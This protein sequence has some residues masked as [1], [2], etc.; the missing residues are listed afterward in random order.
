M[1]VYLARVDRGDDP[2]SALLEIYGTDIASL[3]K[4][5]YAYARQG[6]YMFFT[7]PFDEGADAGESKLQPLEPPEAIYRLSDLLAHRRPLPEQEVLIYAQEV[8]RLVPD[9]SG[10]HEILGYVEDTKGNLSEARKY[11]ELAI[12]HD[13]RNATAYSRCG[14]T[15]LRE[16]DKNGQSADGEDTPPLLLEARD[17]LEK[18]LEIN[19]DDPETLA[20]LGRTYRYDTGEVSA[21]ISA[22]VRATQALPSRTDILYSLIVLTARSGNPAGARVLLERSLRSRG[23]D[24]EVRFAERAIEVAEAN[25]VIDRYNEAISAMNGGEWKRALALLNEVIRRARDAGLKEA[26]EGH[27]IRVEGRLQEELPA[28]G[29]SRP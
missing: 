13:P 6:Q 20:A 16:F 26:A 3:E 4:N 2:V 11:Y 29:G 5:L 14:R 27:K 1:G 24:E 21:G 17:R 7:L 18:S 22:L 23:D 19:P 9:H 12:R 8:L 25:Q 28:A 10:A 15:Y